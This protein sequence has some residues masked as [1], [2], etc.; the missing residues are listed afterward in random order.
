MATRAANRHTPP[1]GRHAVL[2]AYEG[3]TSDTASL[4]TEVERDRLEQVRLNATVDKLLGDVGRLSTG[5][6]Q[7][8]H[9]MA[10]LRVDV[11]NVQRAIPTVPDPLLAVLA[12]HSAELREQLTSTQQVVAELAGRLTDV[13][14]G[15]L[16]GLDAH[17]DT[18]VDSVA[19]TDT[20]DDADR[21]QAEEPDEE[22][23][24]RVVVRGPTV[25]R[26]DSVPEVQQQNG[27]A[28]PDE[29]DLVRIAAARLHAVR[30]ALDG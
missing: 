17:A 11:R 4:R 25:T 21:H 13:L 5:L 28:V 24:R 8:R 10:A 16:E 2:A 26:L 22:L 1:R 19:A 15:R 29:L 23:A 6:S 18:A 12:E 27:M 7:I 9:E 20:M 14:T 30:R 3:L